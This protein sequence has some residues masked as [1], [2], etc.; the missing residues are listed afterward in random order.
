MR[1]RVEFESWGTFAFFSGE[2]E[3]ERE[4]KSEFKFTRRSAIT[5]TFLPQI[6]WTPLVAD[7]T[8][9][10]G[11]IEIWSKVGYLGTVRDCTKRS[12][13]SDSVRA[14][15]RGIDCWCWPHNH[16]ILS[17][18]LF[19]VLFHGSRGMTA[20]D[21]S[22]CRSQTSLQVLLLPSVSVHFVSFSSFSLSSS[23]TVQH[24]NLYLHPTESYKC[25]T[26]G[27]QQL[28]NNLA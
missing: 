12:V 7:F 1:R 14:V 16:F 9:D 21:K 19:T 18:P 28:W 22:S 8:L 23:V 13:L 26:I 5:R 25:R 27:E 24:V 6:T 11:Y 3:R 2:R 20:I 4:R 10:V 15:R 17:D